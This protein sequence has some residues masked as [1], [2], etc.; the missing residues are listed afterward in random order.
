MHPSSSVRVVDSHIADPI[1]SA[2]RYGMV[3]GDVPGTAPDG[4]CAHAEG[5]RFVRRA[6]QSTFRLLSCLAELI[7]S[8]IG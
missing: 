5:W 3:T 8:K 1:G 2:E 7:V 6:A 4:S